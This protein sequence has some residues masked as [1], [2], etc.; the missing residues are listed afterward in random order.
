MFISNVGIDLGY[1]FLKATNGSRD[2]FFP[3]VVGLGADLA[4][5]SELSLY[6]QEEDNLV[7]EIGGARYFVGSL[8]VRQSEIAARSL[9]E[10]RPGDWS[11]RVL[12]LTA[13]SLVVDGP[14]A[15]ANIV[16]GLPPA[17][18]RLYRD[19]LADIMLGE[20]RVVLQSGPRPAEKVIVV[21]NV[22]VVP[23]PFGTVFDLFLDRAGTVQQPDLAASRVGVIDIGFRTT[24]LVVAD[25]LDY[26]ERLSVTTTTGL[27]T[28]YALIADALQ[29]EFG[30]T[31]E[32][33]EL[34]GIVMSGHLRLGGK[35]HDIS[36][37][38]DDAF[39]Q[40]AR[41]IMTEVDSVWQKDDLDVVYVTGGGGQA[42]A[43]FLLEALPNGALVPGAQ[44]AN[45]HGYWKLSNK[46]FGV[47]S[48]YAPAMAEVEAPRTESASRFDHRAAGDR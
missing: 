44:A 40:V 15:H 22:R 4:Y 21:D 45:V 2:I 30:I 18:Y 38:R 48:G 32:N 12:F 3:S 7:V 29:R 34:D 1:G 16:T 39:R 5:H 41:K 17:H 37:V 23:Q 19:A 28:A 20:H 11:A 36:Q 33:Y 10:D 14:T 27:A 42:L 31:R 13:L 6:T 8:A 24:D 46:L 47:G 35:V 25:R 43:G 26:V 9:A